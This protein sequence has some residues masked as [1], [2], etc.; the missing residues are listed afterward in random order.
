MYQKKGKFSNLILPPLLAM[1]A[2]LVDAEKFKE[3]LYG[4]RWV[5]L[6][7]KIYKYLKKIIKKNKDDIK[8]KEY[9]KLI[10]DIKH[11]EEKNLE[12]GVEPLLS[13]DQKTFD[14]G[15]KKAIWSSFPVSFYKIKNKFGVEEINNNFMKYYQGKSEEEIKN[16]FYITNSSI[17]KN[18]KLFTFYYF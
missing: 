15:Q 1:S 18:K 17:D 10:K 13:K 9:Y 3:N 4:I 16:S 2:I 5:D 11:D 12:L 6:D 7:K 8:I 14:W